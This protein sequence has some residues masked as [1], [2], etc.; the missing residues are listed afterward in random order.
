MWPKNRSLL[1]V[2]IYE[3]G[4]QLV[5]SRTSK[6]DTCRIY[7]ILKILRRAHMSNASMRAQKNCVVVHVSQPYINDIGL[8]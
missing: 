7:G 4:P 5:M 6:L 1:S 2:T 3:S 8:I